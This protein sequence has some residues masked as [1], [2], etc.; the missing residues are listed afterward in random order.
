MEKIQAV[1]Q[2]PNLGII[3]VDLDPSQ[4]QGLP[5]QAQ[6]LTIV[7]QFIDLMMH[8]AFHAMNGIRVQIKEKGML[9]PTEVVLHLGNKG[10][11]YRRGKAD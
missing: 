5:V 3:V 2:D 1:P 4:W 8:P 9:I 6:I 10:N 11:F 7:H